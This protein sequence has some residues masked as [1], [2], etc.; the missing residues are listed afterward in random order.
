MK[1]KYKSFKGTIL[2]GT[3]E[4]SVALELDPGEV[5]V[6]CLFAEKPSKDVVIKIVDANGS[7][8]IDPSNYQDWEQRQGG[9]YETSKKPLGFEGGQKVKVVATS[10][11]NQ[12]ADWD[13][14][15]LLL[16]K[17]P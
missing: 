6:G 14:E 16:I 5:A 8:I 13:F 4:D 12:T 7:A 9:N 2:S 3:N 1:P 17:Q 15:V 10:V 11:I